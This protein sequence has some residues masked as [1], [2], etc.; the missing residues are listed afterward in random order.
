MDLR[1]FGIADTRHRDCSPSRRRGLVLK[2]GR[3]VGRYLYPL[4]GWGGFKVEGLSGLE[5]LG[6]RLCD[7]LL[8]HD[9]TRLQRS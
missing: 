9:R 5:S 2:P 3:A 4:Q 6:G 1:D 7:I 8:E